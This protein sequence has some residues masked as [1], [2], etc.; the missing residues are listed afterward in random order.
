MYSI[1]DDFFKWSVTMGSCLLMHFSLK[2]N[3]LAV[4]FILPEI[5]LIQKMKP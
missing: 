5:E 1:T 2:E 4:K 3:E